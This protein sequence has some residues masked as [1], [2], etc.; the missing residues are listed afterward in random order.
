IA[1][2]IKKKNYQIIPNRQDAID[3]AIAE[4]KKNDTVVITGKGHEK[5]LCRG[6]IEYPWDEYEAVEKALKI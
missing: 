1:S 4:A 3:K 6:K 5:S 2:G